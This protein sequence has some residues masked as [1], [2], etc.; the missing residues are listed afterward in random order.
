MAPQLAMVQ[1]VAGSM[2]VRMRA[3]PSPAASSTTPRIR[4]P[5]YAPAQQALNAPSYGTIVQPA[6]GGVLQTV[7]TAPI[8]PNTLSAGTNLAALPPAATS[9]DG[10]RPRSSMR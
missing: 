6:F 5:G 1:P 2:A 10:F 9:G 3:V 8:P 7:K 4:L